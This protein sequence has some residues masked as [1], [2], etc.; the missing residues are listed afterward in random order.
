MRKSANMLRAKYPQLSGREL[1]KKL[2]NRFEFEIINN[3]GSHCTLLRKN[4][5]PPILLQVYMHDELKRGTLSAIIAN[6]HISRE[7]FL[8][9]MR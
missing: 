2:C 8:E 6:A 1:A 9:S 3:N 7:E 5:Y 4:H